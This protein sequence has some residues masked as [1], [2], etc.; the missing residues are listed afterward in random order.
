[1]QRLRFVRQAETNRAR[2]SGSH[3]DA[4]C[5]CCTGYEARVGAAEPHL[6]SRASVGFVDTEFKVS[7]RVAGE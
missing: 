6:V 4:C 5:V 7:I 3:M 2:S 1:V